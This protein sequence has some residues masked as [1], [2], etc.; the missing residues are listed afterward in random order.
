MNGGVEHAVQ[1][2]SRSE[3]EAAKNAYRFF[4]FEQVAT[5]LAE[6]AACRLVDETIPD[7]RYAEIITS[8]STLFEKFSTVVLGQPH[9]F[10]PA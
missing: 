10:A 9:L 8:D 6:A 1:V 7:R 4:S 3:L 2:L 5:L